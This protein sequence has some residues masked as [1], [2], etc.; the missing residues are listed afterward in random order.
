MREA[1]E[2]DVWDSGRPKR[3]CISRHKRVSADERLVSD[4]KTYYKVEVLSSKLRSSDKDKGPNKQ[5]ETKAN[6]SDKG[7]IV[8]FKKLRNSELIQLNNEATNFLFP[9]KDD[10]SDDDEEEEDDE[11]E[12]GTEEEKESTSSEH[13]EGNF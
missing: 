6:D 10:T 7:L 13:N 8:K 4:N 5:K 9:K 12:N 2:P 3:A 11:E 1:T